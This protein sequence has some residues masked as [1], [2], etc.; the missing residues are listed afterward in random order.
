MLITK[1][2]L[3]YVLEITKYLYFNLEINQEIEVKKITQQ[4]NRDM[5]AAALDFI[6]D[7][8]LTLLGAFQI[9]YTDETRESIKKVPHFLA[10]EVEGMKL[11]KH[12]MPFEFKM[13]PDNKPLVVSEKYVKLLQYG[14][15]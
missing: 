6:I 1:K 10:K 9:R 13:T 14:N 15:T 2:S 4:N 8:N 7:R 11:D 3:N 5:F 12:V